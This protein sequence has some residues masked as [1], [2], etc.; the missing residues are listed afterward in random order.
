MK[1]KIIKKEKADNK[2]VYPRLMEY[3][4]TKFSLIV[5]TKSKNFGMVIH[6]EDKDG[7][8]VGDTYDGMVNFEDHPFWKPFEGTIELSN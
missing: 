2:I 4:E 7:P 5:L 3:I 6:S 8:Y 1:S